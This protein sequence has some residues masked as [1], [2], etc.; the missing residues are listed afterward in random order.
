MSKEDIENAI[1]ITKDGEVIRCFGDKNGAYP[2]VDFGEKLY[3]AYVTHNHPPGSSNEYSFSDA[4]IRL[5]RGYELEMLRGIDEKYIYEMD[6][7]SQE[8]D[9]HCVSIFDLTDEDGRHESVIDIAQKYGFGYRRW[10]R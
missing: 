8:T 7:N 5:F 3:G 1:V 2:D 10:S 4:D 6:K 9:E